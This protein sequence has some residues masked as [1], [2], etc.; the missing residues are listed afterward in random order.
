MRITGFLLNVVIF[1]Y[2]LI[3]LSICFLALEAIFESFNINLS[4]SKNS[5]GFIVGAARATH[6]SKRKSCSQ[7]DDLISLKINNNFI[8]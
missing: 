2:F 6:S 7:I 3:I 5:A 4:D 8:F 1:S